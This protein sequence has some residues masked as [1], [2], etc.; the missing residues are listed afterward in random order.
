MIMI[1]IFIHKE[2]EEEE[3]DLSAAVKII[4]NVSDCH[5]APL[6]HFCLLYFILASQCFSNI[7]LLDYL[8]QYLA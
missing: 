7:Y 3:E 4:I 6:P 8:L 2:E 5:L 1:I